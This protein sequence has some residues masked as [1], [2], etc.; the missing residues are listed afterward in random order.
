[1]LATAYRSP[2]ASSLLALQARAHLGLDLR[3]WIRQE[4]RGNSPVKCD[5]VQT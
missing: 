1:M 3:T 5:Q 4:S 2:V